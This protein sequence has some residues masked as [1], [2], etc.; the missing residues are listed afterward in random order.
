MILFNSASSALFHPI[1]MQRALSWGKSLC[2]VVLTVVIVPAHPAA[3]DAFLPMAA[4]VQ[5]F[6]TSSTPKM[7]SGAQRPHA[8]P[9]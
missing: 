6:F 9:I 2:P 1:T 3:G 5:R 8:P 4:F 7:A